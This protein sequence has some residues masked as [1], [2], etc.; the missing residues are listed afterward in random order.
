MKV[1]EGEILLIYMKL[2]HNEM[3]DLLDVIDLT[4]W[5]LCD[6]LTYQIVVLF[7]LD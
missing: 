2:V 4:L 1:L 5:G 7:E 3:N 6:I